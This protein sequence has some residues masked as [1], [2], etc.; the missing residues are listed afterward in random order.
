MLK[1]KS[2]QCVVGFPSI[3]RNSRSPYQCPFLVEAPFPKSDHTTDQQGDAR[4]T[5]VL[6]SLKPHWIGKG[7]IKLT[8]ILNQDWL[9]AA[10]Q[11][12]YNKR[13][14][15]GTWK[16][17]CG[18]LFLLSSTKMWV[19]EKFPV[20]AAECLTTN[21]REV[22]GTLRL[23]FKY[24]SEQSRVS[25][26]VRLLI[27]SPFL[28]SNFV[29]RRI[30]HRL[31]SPLFGK[32]HRIHELRICLSAKHWAMFACGDFAEKVR[33]YSNKRDVYSVLTEGVSA[34]ALGSRP[35]PRIRS[36]TANDR[37]LSK[38]QR[39]QGRRG[40]AELSVP[41]DWCN[42]QLYGPFHPCISIT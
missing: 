6:A 11:R 39:S 3:F 14:R 8:V 13:S 19:A 18:E 9:K 33:A 35:G 42:R 26:T 30:F 2:E 25:L 5:R 40:A 32:L 16:E 4:L 24:S 15:M 31:L 27:C 37:E 7:F 20:S 28:L 12:L 1:E 34:D 36:A 22:V 21:E 29:Y 23:K 41:W 38:R 17:F 10:K